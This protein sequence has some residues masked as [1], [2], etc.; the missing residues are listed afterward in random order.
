MSQA[1]N[2]VQMV[3]D[4]QHGDIVSGRGPD[5]G[6]QMINLVHRQR[7]G[8]LIQHQEP[9]RVSR[10]RSHR[11]RKRYTGTLCGPQIGELR[12]RVNVQANLS[13]HLAGSFCRPP[14]PDGDRPG[15]IATAEK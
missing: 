4:K 5:H 8:G 7:G 11:A 2:L 9:G 6:V 1:E 15:R 14:R 3:R 13:Q 10:I 12:R